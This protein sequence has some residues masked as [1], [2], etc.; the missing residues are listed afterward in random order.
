ML[1]PVLIGLNAF[2]VAAE[3]ALVSL[4]ASQI[5]PMRGAGYART[6]RALQRLKDDMPAAIGAIQV[7]ITMSNLLL[8]WIGE[9]ALSAVLYKALAPLDIILPPT[10]SAVLS[11]GLGFLI[12]TL[13]TVVLSELLPKA[14]T[15]QHTVLVA[16]F[17]LVPMTAVMPAITPLV[18]LMN[19]LANLITRSMGLGPVEIE[20]RAMTAEEI[21]IITAESGDAGALSDRERTL[22]LNSLALGKRMAREIRVPRVHLAVLDV[23]KPMSVNMRIVEERLFT[24]FPV[25][26]GSIDRIIGIIN[27]K[28]LLTAR[29]EQPTDDTAI[30]QLLLRPAVFAP[31]NI[32]VDR[33][34]TLFS[35]H[36]TEMLILVDEFGGVDGVVTMKDVI[37]ELVGET[38]TAD[39][40]PATLTNGKT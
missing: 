8:G 27:A 3:Y 30:L 6:A 13:L 21:G 31:L 33:L 40:D 35:E 26:D 9:P 1:V 37:D 39:V 7:C 20:G 5:E 12:V 19:G 23:Q 14:L 28:A 18:W 16:R 4:R 29:L 24:R 38:K 22:I 36:H 11:T 15:L 25:C 34:L 10:V 32:S 2:F 17:T